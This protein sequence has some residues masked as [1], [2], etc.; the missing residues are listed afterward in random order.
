MD[1]EIT[2]RGVKSI[3]GK[4]VL[5][6]NT[7]ASAEQRACSNVFGFGGEVRTGLVTLNSPVA[8]QV[9]FRENERGETMIFSNLFHTGDEYRPASKHEWKILVTDIL[10]TKRER[11]CDYLSILL[12][13]D[14]VYDKDCSTTNHQS[15]KIGDLT[16]KHGIVL[17][18]VVCH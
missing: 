17:F 3:W 7:N 2:L 12:D 10:D 5:L 8:G 6:R 1:G 4:S 13:P 16:K 15:C 9:M 18:F 14:N 11:K